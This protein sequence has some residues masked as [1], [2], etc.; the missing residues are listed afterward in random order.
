MALIELEPPRTL[1]RGTISRRL[2]RV[3]SGSDMNFQ[4]VRSSAMALKASAGMMMSKRLSLPPASSRSTLT[5]GS[6]LSRLAST[7]PA[8]PA[9]MTM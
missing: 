3:G 4:L 9:P 8:E 5:D 2:F 7:Q 6:A 1:P